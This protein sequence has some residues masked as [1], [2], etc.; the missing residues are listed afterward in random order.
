MKTLTTL[1]PCAALLQHAAAQG[2]YLFTID[3]TMTSP[4]TSMID[5][6]IASAI[7]ARRRALTADRYL[8][9]TDEIL[10]E[11]LNTYGGYQAPLFRDGHAGEAPGK[12]FIR[13]SGVDIQM[14]D[15]DH[16]MPDLWIQEPTKDLLTDF[17]AV[18]DR[19]EKD[20]LC[21]YAVPASLNAPD[22]KGVEVVFTYPMENVCIHVFR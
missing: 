16:V 1:L 2:A 8:G 11:D 14:N 5:S 13:I 3:R 7:I 12:L 9:T 6:E 15:F 19:K 18:S 4:S 17:K 22:S 21:E 20:G 10:L